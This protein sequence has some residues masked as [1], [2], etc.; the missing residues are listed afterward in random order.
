MEPCNI[1]E[2]N[3]GT[4][5]AAHDDLI[6]HLSSKHKMSEELCAEGPE[7]RKS[8]LEVVI[9]TVLTKLKQ[10]VHNCNRFRK[11]RNAWT[12]ASNVA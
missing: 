8:I 2:P 7:R 3:G 5:F 11:A 10:N 4:Y 6:E 12:R 9:L 1:Y